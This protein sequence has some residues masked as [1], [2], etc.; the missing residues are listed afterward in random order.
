MFPST[1]PVTP[2]FLHALC[3]DKLATD[4][5]LDPVNTAEISISDEDEEKVALQE[6]CSLA[7]P[8]FDVK[9]SENTLVYTFLAGSS[10]SDLGLSR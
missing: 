7:T 2:A 5:V 1:T 8:C 4:T 10:I 9:L 3:Y 6:P